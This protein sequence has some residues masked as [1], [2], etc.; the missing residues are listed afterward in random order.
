MATINEVYVRTD[1]SD[2]NGGSSSDAAGDSTRTNCSSNAAL[3]EITDDDAGDWE[4]VASVGDW[5]CF[6]TAGAK[7]ITRIT[8]IGGVGNKTLT[9]SPN[10]GAETAGDTVT[11]GGAWATLDRA[12]NNIGEL[13]DLTRPITVNVK[14]GTYNE[15]M[16]IDTAAANSAWG[17]VFE[18]YSAT[19]GDGSGEAVV[20]ASGDAGHAC[21][22]DSLGAGT[23]AYYKFIR[24]LFTASDTGG[25]SSTC[26]LLSFENCRFAANTGDGCNVQHFSLFYKCDFYSNSGDGLD[27]SGSYCTA[28][29][30]KSYSNTGKG[31]DFAG[32]TTHVINC[33][34]YANGTANVVVGASGTSS[35]VYGCTVDCNEAANVIGIQV[36]NTA[37]VANNIVINHD[38]NNAAIY[39]ASDRAE[40]PTID[41]NLFYANDDDLQNLVATNSLTGTAPTLTP[42]RA[43]DTDDTS[44]DQDAAAVGRNVL[45]PSNRDVGATQRRRVSGAFFLPTKR[46]GKQ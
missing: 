33:I 16:T 12:M 22:E 19:P 6:D 36:L 27:I 18:A 25:V 5:I 39:S 38:G 46:A 17:I 3:D 31:I 43:L 40:F 35:C 20:N 28:A 41:Y 24:F 4:D 26:D 21:L 8:A 15:Y 34:C 32:N 23:D 9:V 37:L 45:V 44:T 2:T 10:V 42:G 29:N 7:D 30:C 1:G 11:V 14:S 13:Q